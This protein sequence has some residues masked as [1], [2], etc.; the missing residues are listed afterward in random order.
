MAI[1][2]SLE[3]RK[4]LCCGWMERELHISRKVVHELMIDIFFQL[5]S[6]IRHLNRYKYK[7]RQK[8]NLYLAGLQQLTTIR[9]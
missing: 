2:D 1:V 3:V 4:R 5:H 6:F 8:G 7:S 9:I